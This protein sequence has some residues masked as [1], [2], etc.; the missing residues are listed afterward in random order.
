MHVIDYGCGPGYMARAVAPLVASVEAVDLSPGALAC[1]R[2]LNSAPNIVYETVTDFGQ[3]DLSADMAYSFAVVQH[4]TDEQVRIALS[5]LHRR[6]RSNGHLILHFARPDNGFKTASEWQQA[7]V[8]SRPIATAACS[9]LLRSQL[10][11]DGT[12]PRRDWI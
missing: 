12:S 3:R 9:A 11:R 7:Q 10:R 8:Y 4:L 6:L 2:I 1:A 5:L